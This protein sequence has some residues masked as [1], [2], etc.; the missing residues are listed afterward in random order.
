VSYGDTVFQVLLV[1]A[2]HHI[3]I[4]FLCWQVQQDCSNCGACL[5]KYFCAKCN[6]FDDDVS[7]EFEFSQVDETRNCFQYISSEVFLSCFLLFVAC[8]LVF[9][10]SKNQ[11]HCDGCGICRQV[12]HTW[13]NLS[14]ILA[15]GFL[16]SV[17]SYHCFYRTGGVENF[18]HCDKCGTIVFSYIIF[19]KE[20]S[21]I[22]LIP[23]SMSLLNFV[24]FVGL[25][26]GRMLLYL[27]S[28]GFSSLRRQSNASKLPCMLWGEYL[29]FKI[30]TK[31][32]FFQSDHLYYSRNC[33]DKSFPN[34]RPF[35]SQYLFE[36]TK[37]VSVLHC[38][39]TIHLQCLYEMRAH[40]Q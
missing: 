40:Q 32:R 27:S 21:S 10:V 3:K 36:S 4:I 13:Q 22:L 14:E 23:S 39:H 19:C 2:G 6:L 7:S 35:L 16:L 31:N 9:Q 29:P 8:S 11:F 33:V 24:L 12:V 20:L 34:Q 25:F 17:L 18:Y 28:E 26:C 30:V 37:A 15:F 5:G 1:L 38:G